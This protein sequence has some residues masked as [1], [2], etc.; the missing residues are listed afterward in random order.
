[1]ERA[2]TGS[3]VLLI[4]AD[5]AEIRSMSDRIV[6]LHA[7]RVAGEMAAAEAD[8]ERIGL[9]MAGSRLRAA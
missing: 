7:G 3:G 1:V 5:L 6:V 4:S 9:L 2:A 8:D